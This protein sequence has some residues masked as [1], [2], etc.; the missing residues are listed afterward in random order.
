[1]NLKKLAKRY[2]EYHQ[3]LE[4]KSTEEMQA[5][6]ETEDV[7]EDVHQIVQKDADE[8][9]KLLDELCKIS[10]NKKY[11]A[12]VG[13][14]PM[15]NFLVQYGE[16]REKDFDKLIENNDNALITLACVWPNSMSERTWGHV[17]ALITMNRDRLNNIFKK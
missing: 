10:T 8:A 4:G 9:L 6:M 2:F 13:A 12:Y 17:Q 7:W 5:V 11:L 15:E 16:E 3:K 1:M 14:G